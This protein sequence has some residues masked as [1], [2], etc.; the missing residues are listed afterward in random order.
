MLRPGYGQATARIDAVDGGVSASAGADTLV[1][2]A[3]MPLTIDQSAVSGR[4]KLHRGESAGFA[5]HYGTAETGDQTGSA[6]VWGQSEIDVRL[7]D[8]V[9]AWESWSEL[10]QAYEG[11]WK[12]LV[13]HSGRVLQSL[14]FAPTGAIC[15]AA[16]TSLPEVVGGPGTGTT[17]TPG[18][19]TLPSRFRPSGLRPALTKPTSSST[20]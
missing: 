6:R 17:A 4:I 16:T 18:S 2:S 9:S 20:T 3:P 14:S 10:H 15:A 19:G 12:D 1:L 8:T 7:Q 13:H 5:L 11:P